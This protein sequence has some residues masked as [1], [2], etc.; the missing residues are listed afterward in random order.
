MSEYFG[1]RAIRNAFERII[2]LTLIA[3]FLAAIVISAANDIF[4]FVKPDTQVSLNITQGTELDDI[5][6]S[7]KNAGIINNPSLFSAFVRSRGNEEKV[8]S[9]V[10]NITFYGKMSYREIMT[11]FYKK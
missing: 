9:F 2:I 4:A 11:S 6:R 10:G 3:I 1:K 8:K 7:L 5:A